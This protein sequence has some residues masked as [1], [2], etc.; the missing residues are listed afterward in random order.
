MVCPQ[1]AAGH[2]KEADALEGRVEA[3]HG[4][5]TYITEPTQDQSP[6]GM[7]VIV[8]DGLGWDLPNTRILADTYA[9]RTGCR[10]YVPDLQAG[11]A[12]PHFLLHG[13]YTPTEHPSPLML[14]DMNYLLLGKAKPWLE[15]PWVM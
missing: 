1:C 14:A 4:L 5:P 10:V 11:H 13:D 7:I 6:K 8:P 3:L 12:I 2:L 9:R 15:L